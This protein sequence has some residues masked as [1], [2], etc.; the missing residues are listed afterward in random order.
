[1]ATLI[2]SARN[3]LLTLF[4]PYRWY[5]VDGACLLGAEVPLR[6][7]ASA[8]HFWLEPPRWTDAPGNGAPRGV[9][10]KPSLHQR[11]DRRSISCCSDSD[12]GV[13]SPRLSNTT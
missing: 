3:R 13:L 12:S 9:C 2:R 10:G 1:M 5:E 4:R 8:S 11:S 6:L 7:S